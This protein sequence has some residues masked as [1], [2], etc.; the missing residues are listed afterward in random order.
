MQNSRPTKPMEIGQAEKIA[1]IVPEWKAGKSP[2]KLHASLCAPFGQPNV[3]HDSPAA[4]W[5]LRARVILNRS[6]KSL[7]GRESQALEQP[8]RDVLDLD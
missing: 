7:S 4:P 2:G 3:G 5:T 6:G 1:C 8:A